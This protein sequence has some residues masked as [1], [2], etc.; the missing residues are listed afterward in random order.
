MI[1]TPL[2]PLKPNHKTQAV[3]LS[4]MLVANFGL[5]FILYPSKSY[6]FYAYVDLPHWYYALATL[7]LG[8]IVFIS[9]LT[10]SIRDPGKLNFDYDK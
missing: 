7:I 9:Y 5:Y 4:M 3:F 6:R 10:A 2:V 1:K 8:L